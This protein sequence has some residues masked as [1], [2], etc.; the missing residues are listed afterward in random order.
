MS[1]PVRP[2]RRLPGLATVP[3]WVLAMGIVIPPLTM[4][5]GAFSRVIVECFML[6]WINF[7][8]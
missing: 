4:C 2:E 7:W 1:K 8:K 3:L 5:I 6:G